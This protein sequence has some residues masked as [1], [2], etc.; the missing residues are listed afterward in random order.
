MTRTFYRQT[1]RRGLLA[2]GALLVTV[3]SASAQELPRFDVKSECQRIARVS[4]SF[5]E[6]T[7]GGCMDME[8]AA[9]NGMK[10]S[11]NTLPSVV[12]QECVRIA[13]V[14]GSGS[15]TT[16]QGCIQMEMSAAEQNRGRQFRY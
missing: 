6:M 4:G 13:A 10:D 12:R 16:L 3:I 9:Y 7:F 14:G 11:W 2:S 5:S 8:Q 1:C 15:Y